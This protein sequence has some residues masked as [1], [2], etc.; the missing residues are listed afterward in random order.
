MA[1]TAGTKLGPYEIAG[2]LGA[3]G[4]GEVYRARDTRLGRD[5]AI[6][7]LPAHLSAS[8]DLRQRLEREAKAISSL[9][10]P[11]I[12]TLHDVGS[13]DGVDFLVM[14]YVEGETLSDRLHRGRLELDEALQLAIQIADAL[15][16]AHARGIVHRDLKP[17][18]IMLTKHGTKLMDFGLAKP[19][20]A[21]SGAAS[22][23]LTPTTPT[24]SV[25]AL[26]GPS[27]PLT[28][29]GTVVG[30]FQYMAPEVLQGAEADA[31]SDVFSFGCVLYEMITGR[32]AFEGKSQFSVLGAILDHEPERVSALR[33][34][35]PPRLDETVRR[36]LAKNPD[37]RYGCMHDVRIQLEA[38]AESAPQA[39]AP[40]ETAK[41][42]PSSSR[43]PWLV[44]AVAVL[45]ALSVAT[46]YFLRAP[47][48][49]PVVQSSILPPTGTSFITLLPSSGPPAFS[50]DG[51]RLAFSARDDKGKV[52]LYVRPLTSLTAQPLAGTDDAIYPFWSA[53]SREIGFFADGKLKKISADGGPPQT[54]CDAANGRGGTWNKDG[55]IVFA[56][57]TTQPLSSISAGGGTPA[58]ASKLNPSQEENS[59][60][61]PS[62]L[63]DGK[64]FLYW[65]RSARGGAE[66]I[67]YLGELGSLQARVILKNESTAAYA[68]DH[69]LFLRDQTLL[70][71]PFN[72]TRMELS[73]DAVPIAEHVGMN[74]ATARPLFSASQTG[75]LIY[76]AGLTE[77][78]WNLLWQGRDGKQLGTAVKADRY[79][80]PVLS[81]DGTH[82][83]VSVFN[84]S[85]GIGDIWV[86]DLVRGTS[87]RLTFGP[88]SKSNPIWTPDGKMV[89]Y[90]STVK[91]PPH[92]Y[93][94][95][96]DGSGAEKTILETPDVI[97]LPDSFS[98]DG[99][100]L[101]YSRH[102]P[103]TE[104]TNHL[105]VL[106]LFGEGKPFPIVQTAFDERLAA[107]SPDSKWM[108]Y[109]NNESG[110]YE[111]YITA[112]PG[113]GPKWQ[114]STNGGISPKWRKDGKEL[115]FIDGADNMVA[116]DVNLSA[117]A[118]HLGVP[119]ALFQVAGVQREYGPYD[120]TADGKKFLINFGNV[121][122]G[123][124][125]LTLVLN[126]PSQLKK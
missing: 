61:W 8:P 102:L 117:N 123:G 56:P 36:C 66:S 74:G 39:A 53:D 49:N 25:A 70:A 63:P 69:L 12:C 44:A 5:V 48:P 110:R 125:P 27:S 68:S 82:V 111:I 30:T 105:W 31:R 97:E 38:L 100:Y 29:K 33:P 57:A 121:N 115:Y 122:A 91:G 32:R 94:R 1:L 46:A 28:Q 14:E 54:L 7:V 79:V 98:P 58:P 92:I 106:P 78:G 85:Q 112:F 62:F 81:P 90:S 96:A 73:G 108:A 37:Q 60:R 4:M 101:V 64:H 118:V 83:A 13:Q 80:S 3:G 126:W 77:G 107:V 72:P 119:H 86:F 71:Q 84:G 113:A 87:T 45:I 76:Q 42:V 21:L 35:S 104:P 22:V 43:L 93:A 2:P 67:V 99:R 52:L 24:I 75:A 15:D 103:K 34:T 19:A 55:M 11:H 41:A 6:K 16:K 51:K 114:V 124:D 116:V 109:W 89:A 95:A 59:H 88:G 50:H 65:A 17:G 20:P 10:H 9:N 47:N 40:P 26:T 23:P 18:N 120:V